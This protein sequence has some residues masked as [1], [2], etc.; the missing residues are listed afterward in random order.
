V[1][2]DRAGDRGAVTPSRRAADSHRSRGGC[3][4]R[5]PGRNLFASQAAMTRDGPTD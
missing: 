2:R 5:R 1:E 4:R 3:L